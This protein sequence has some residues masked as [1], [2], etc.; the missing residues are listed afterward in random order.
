[1]EQ[2]PVLGLKPVE[3]YLA[4]RPDLPLEKGD[5]V[6]VSALNMELIAFQIKGEF[7]GIK[8]S[9]GVKS[10]YI[11]VTNVLTQTPPLISREI[12]SDN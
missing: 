5:S 11:R 6:A 8:R 12:P 9:R 10:G 7:L 1:M 4:I 2:F 3:D